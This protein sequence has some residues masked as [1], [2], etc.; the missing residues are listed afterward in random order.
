MSV[1]GHRTPTRKG[2][3]ITSKGKEKTHARK[4]MNSVIPWS[5]DCWAPSSGTL[6]GDPEHDLPSFAPGVRVG[7]KMPRVRAVYPRK[8]PPCGA[9]MFERFFECS[10]RA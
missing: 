1:R 7:V 2:V 10:Q 4:K 8:A 9:C 5:S 6:A 3:P